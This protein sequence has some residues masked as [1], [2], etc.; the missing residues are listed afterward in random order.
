M[1][2]RAW[3]HLLPD[4]HAGVIVLFEGVELETAVVLRRRG[5]GLDRVLGPEVLRRM[6]GRLDGDLRR[7]PRAVREA[8]ERE[9]GPMAFGVFAPT[10]TL[11]ELLMSRESGAWAGAL[12]RREVV[13]DPMPPWAA[14]AAGAGALHAVGRRSRD[15]LSTLDALGVFGPFSKRA[16]EVG[17]LLGSVDVRAMLG[18]DPLDVVG[19]ILRG[20]ANA[21]HPDDDDHEP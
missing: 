10:T 13:L 8:V 11:R 4:G 15:V 5:A 16:R 9:L 7:D 3:D 21:A 20:S 19:T 1:S 14:V 18:F 12:A 6:V 2:G 17:E